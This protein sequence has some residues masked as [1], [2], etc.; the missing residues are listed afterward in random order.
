MTEIMSNSKPAEDAFRAADLSNYYTKKIYIQMIDAKFPQVKNKEQLL[1][2][3]QKLTNHPDFSK[4]NDANKTLAKLSLLI[5]NGVDIKIIKANYKLSKDMSD[6]LNDIQFTLHGD[7]DIITQRQSVAALYHSGDYETFKILNDVNHTK[8]LSAEDLTQMDDL[9]KWAEEN[10][11]LLVKHTN[12]TNPNAIPKQ[13]ITIDY[14]DMATHKPLGPRTFDVRVIDLHDENVLNNL[15]KYGFEP[16][17]TTDDLIKVEPEVLWDGRGMNEVVVYNPQVKAL[18]VR[19]G[20]IKSIPQA[21][22]ELSEKYN[23]PII[24]QGKYSYS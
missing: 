8:N 19:G 24:V 6:R 13:Q 11:N 14:L 7:G 18:Y 17:I 4:L 21:Y 23:I 9:Y 3:L 5:E 22:F 12:I 10:G 1:D 20:N 2:E 16:E 15:E